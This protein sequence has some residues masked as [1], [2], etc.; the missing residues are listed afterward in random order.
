MLTAI[1]EEDYLLTK[2]WSDTWEALYKSTP[3]K[4]WK[5]VEL[6]RKADESD[7]HYSYRLFY[8]Y[9]VSKGMREIGQFLEMDWDEELLGSVILSRHVIKA[10]RYALKHGG[11]N[12]LKKYLHY[13]KEASY[14][15]LEGMTCRAARFALDNFQAATYKKKQEAGRRGGMAFRK[16][17]LEEYLETYNMTVAEAARAMGV[18]RPTVYKMRKHF[19]AVFS[20]NTGEVFEEA[21]L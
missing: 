2:E 10:N 19:D 7:Y 13:S 4:E 1:I 5:K 3:K 18:T 6:Q 8:S 15:Q 21:A 11:F 20:I 12:L 9:L 17:D 14:A 16:W